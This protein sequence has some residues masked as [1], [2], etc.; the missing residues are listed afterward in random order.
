ML[1]AFAFLLVLVVIMIRKKHENQ[2]QGQSQVYGNFK[3]KRWEGQ[4][5]SMIKK[6]YYQMEDRDFSTVHYE[7]TNEDLKW[8]KQ[9]KIKQEVF[10]QLIDLFEKQPGTG[11]RANLT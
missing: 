10:E 2:T 3:Y 7:A 11:L 5:E 4:Q 6:V 9:A 1:A 8:I